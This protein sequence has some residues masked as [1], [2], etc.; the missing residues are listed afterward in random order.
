MSELAEIV[1]A[2]GAKIIII[3]GPSGG[4]Q[5]GRPAPSEIP[6][7][8]HPELLPQKALKEHEKRGL[9]FGFAETLQ[10]SHG[11]VSPVLTIDEIVE[12]E[13]YSANIVLLA[14]QCGFDGVEVHGAN[15]Y[16]LD[17]FLLI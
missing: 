4:R 15:G 2:F 12:L 16:L 8:F 11:A 13:D 7:E 5:F 3:G 17:Q 6:M 1:H 9:R 14:R 10:R